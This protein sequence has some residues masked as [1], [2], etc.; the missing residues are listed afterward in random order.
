ME[1]ATG[2]HVLTIDGYS[3]TNAALS[4]GDYIESERFL[5]GGHSWYIE[6]YPCGQD[7]EAAGWLSVYLSLDHHHHGAMDGEVKARSKF[8]L[9]NRAGEAFF[10]A[11]SKK[12]MTFSSTDDSWGHDIIKITELEELCLLKDDQ[13][14]FRIRCDVTVIR[15]EPPGVISA[16]RT[17]VISATSLPTKR[18]VRT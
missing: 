18:Q 4:V 13:D 17:G 6:C 2:S 12:V 15:E 1:P 14:C 11:P 7:E 10:E 3:K 16:T 8:V 5:V 9:Q